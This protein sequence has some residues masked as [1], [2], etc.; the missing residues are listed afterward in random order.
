MEKFTWADLAKAISEMPI[1]QQEKEVFV[2]IGEKSRFRKIDSIRAVDKDVFVNIFV[3]DDDIGTMQELKDAHG[4]DF[5]FKSY[6]L[7][8]PSGFKFLWDGF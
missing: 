4:D 6:R 3:D 7:L 5:K 8:T 2:S 1:E